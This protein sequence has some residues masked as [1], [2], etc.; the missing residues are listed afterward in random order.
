M[1]LLSLLV[2]FSIYLFRSGR[3]LF[4][5]N[6]SDPDRTFKVGIL[7]AVVGY[8]ATGMFN[9]SITSIAPIFWTLLGLGIAMIDVEQ[10]V[11]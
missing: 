10:K 8:L 3:E 9:D 5:W 1:A 7:C 2:V 4:R 6:Q 11:G